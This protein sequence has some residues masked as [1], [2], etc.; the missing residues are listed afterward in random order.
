[1][2]LDLKQ[3][4]LLASKTRLKHIKSSKERLFNVTHNTDANFPA[5]GVS[6]FVKLQNQT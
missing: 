4:W 3:E 5:A 1:M 2:R 6:P